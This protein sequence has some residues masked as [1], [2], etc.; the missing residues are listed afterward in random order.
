MS[1]SQRSYE[2]IGAGA[3]KRAG[4]EM[5]NSFIIA[6]VLTALAA[7]VICFLFSFHFSG[8]FFGFLIIAEVILVFAGVSALFHAGYCS[9]QKHYEPALWMSEGRYRELKEDYKEF[10]ARRKA[11]A[12]Y[13]FGEWVYLFS[14]LRSRSPEFVKEFT[15]WREEQS[16]PSEEDKKEES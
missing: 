6:G 2:E 4:R 5:R 13:L 1:D 15:A 8:Y 7:A 3:A 12:D 14:F 10:A 9:A 11:H 16:Q